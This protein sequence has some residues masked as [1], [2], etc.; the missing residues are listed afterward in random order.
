MAE[1]HRRDAWGRTSAMMALLANCH[2]DPK[3][4][5][6]FVPAYFDPFE[7]KPRA[8][9]PAVGIEILKAVFIDGKLPG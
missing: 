6:P 7:Q 1:A 2:R 5:R 8:E 9:E 3:R 4:A